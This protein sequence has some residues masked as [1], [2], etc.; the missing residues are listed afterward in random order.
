M[1]TASVRSRKRNCS[2]S[3]V[4]AAPDSIPL[5]KIGP[6]QALDGRHA[7]VEVHRVDLRVEGRDLEA[8]VDAGERAPSGLVHHRD[9]RPGVR[10]RGQPVE[11]VQVDPLVG[12]ALGVA[13]RR[14]AEDVEREADAIAVQRPESGDGA[15]RIAAD[16]EALREPLHLAADDGARE[17]SHRR[18]L[19]READA[20][21]QRRRHGHALV[22][23][24]LV[25]VAGDLGA[26]A[27]R[28][29]DVDEAEHLHLET[30]V[31]HGP[32]HHLALQALPREPARLLSGH[33]GEDG[34]GGLPHAFLG[35]GDGAHRRTLRQR[36]RLPKRS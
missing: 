6:Q 26:A 18:A 16:D 27:K 14:F 30:L 3:S 21:T 36:E 10:R 25:Q 5:R 13:D 2:R 7:A 19:P 4:S 35:A 31:R 20:P 28:G 1:N 8:E 29:E 11:Q 9:R 22:C 15:A 32:F 34:S 12:A 17:R 33:G 23:E 24:V